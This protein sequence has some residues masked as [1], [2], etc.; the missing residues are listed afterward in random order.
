MLL[1][2]RAPIVDARSSGTVLKRVARSTVVRTVPRRVAC[3]VSPIA[4][5]QLSR[6]ESTA[7]WRPDYRAGATGPTTTG[8]G[9]TAESVMAT[10]SGRREYLSLAVVATVLVCAVWLARSHAES[11]KQFIDHHA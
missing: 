7:T 5:S 3:P 11:L 4:H 2:L 9:F 1:H 6:S 8:T 10:Q